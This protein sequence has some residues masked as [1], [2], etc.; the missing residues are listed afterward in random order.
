MLQVLAPLATPFFVDAV[1]RLM[2]AAWVVMSPRSVPAT[3]AWLLVLLLPVPFFPVIAYLLVGENR[4]G[5]G[6]LRRYRE[7]TRVFSE[8]AQVFLQALTQDW[9][10][11]QQ[12][13]RPLAGVL[14]Q[15]GEIPPLRGNE[16][17]WVAGS[18]RFIEGLIRD[19]DAAHQQVHLLFF[20]WMERSA[21]EAVV[22]AVERAARR[23]VRCRVIVDAVGS[24][25]FVRLGLDD[26]LR[27]AG[28]KVAIALPV[29][30]IRGLFARLDLRNH[31]K[32][33]VIDGETAWTGSSNITDDR[34]GVTKFRKVGPW[35]DAMVRIRGPAAQALEAVFLRDWVCESGEDTD[36]SALKMLRPVGEIGEGC[37]VQVVP[38]GPDT[39]PATMRDALVTA[40]FLARREL[41]MT[42]PYF[43]P[44]EAVKEALVAA[45]MRGVE[46]SIVVPR[47]LDN[48]VVGAASRSHFTELLRAGVKI[49]LHRGGLLHSKT[50][51]IDSDVAMI[52][53]HNLDE[54]SFR[55]NFEVSVF[56]YDE[57][58]TSLLRMLQ[59]Q[60]M[61]ESVEIHAEEWER[62]AL[63]KRFLERCARLLG[64]LL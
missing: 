42:T 11:D 44:D 23:G 46:V 32:I 17:E 59:T 6:R 10:P 36:E 22:E 31:R 40:F 52:G 54:R 15:V 12:P 58:Q 9:T 55:L 57:D 28:A 49:Y 37:P 19:I 50:I 53:S 5:G 47:D 61:Q 1:L 21:G 2:L 27:A 43:V 63:W 56:I 3:L 60:Y 30:P 24:K 25:G 16:I 39:G 14:T 41:I 20:I 8:K 34:F 13:Y 51:T 29:N 62:R 33:A 45:A 18:D 26:R 64:P 35:I 4:L 7:T 48:V 38:T